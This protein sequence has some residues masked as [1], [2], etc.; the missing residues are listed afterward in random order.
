VLVII[1]KGYESGPKN[2]PRTWTTCR[3]TGKTWEILPAATSDSNYDMGSLYLEEDGTWRIIAPTET[4]P[5]PYNPGGEVAMWTSRDRGKT[6]N[7]VKQLTRNSER[8]HTYV[9]RP[10]NAHPGFYA[11][12][13]DG[14][15][16]KPSASWLYF[17]DKEGTVRR[18]PREMKEEFEEPEV[19]K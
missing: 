13:A 19:V 7:K 14:H 2:D 1:S 16:R 10:V 11:I 6:W 3:W 12:W 15:G 17:C 4:G 8:N 9:R 18:L 5:Q